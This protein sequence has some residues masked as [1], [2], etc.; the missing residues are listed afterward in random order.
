MSI[1]I[2]NN[3]YFILVIIYN[4]YNLFI[5]I[6]KEPKEARGMREDEFIER[7]KRDPGQGD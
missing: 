5:I 2:Y 4:N 7:V 1:L 6:Y 3:I